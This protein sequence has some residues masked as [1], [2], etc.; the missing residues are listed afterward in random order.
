MN[1]DD[2]VSG[3]GVFKGKITIMH[4][5]GVFFNSTGVR[6]GASAAEE[7]FHLL[8]RYPFS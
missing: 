5:D 8:G 1:T 3:K 2:R 6:H 4:M 7:R